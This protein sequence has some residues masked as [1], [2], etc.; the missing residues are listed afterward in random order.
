M[1]DSG[2]T[3]PRMQRNTSY[4]QSTSYFR[5]RGGG[6]RTS[7]A[8]PRMAAIVRTGRPSGWVRTA[9][10]AK[11]SRTP[12]AQRPR[13]PRES[14]LA[15]SHHGAIAQRRPP[16]WCLAG[17]CSTAFHRRIALSDKRLRACPR[18]D[19]TDPLDQRGTV[20]LPPRPLRPLPTALD[21]GRIVP[22][23]ESGRVINRKSW[24]CFSTSDAL[25]AHRDATEAS[26]DTVPVRAPTLDLR[27]RSRHRRDELASDGRG[28][29][30]PSPP[31]DA[32]RSAGRP[33]SVLDE[34][35]T[36]RGP[37]STSNP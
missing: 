36:A 29:A 12:A 30:R 18:G 16:S 7:T 19:G 32:T 31:V 3:T 35:A 15:R 5:G 33:M 24:L 11:A 9:G 8:H 6:S 17:R 2:P 4:A 22:Q 20:Y 14:P 27:H 28:A 26:G 37:A 13:H 21:A 25:G 23:R 1:C 34:R 10:R